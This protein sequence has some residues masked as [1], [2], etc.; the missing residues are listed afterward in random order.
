MS[1]QEIP[2]DVQ[3]K[4][5]DLETRA[6]WLDSASETMDEPKYYQNQAAA[7]WEEARVLAAQYGLT[8]E[9]ED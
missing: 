9:L 1:I 7:L 2:A 4:I 3:E 6:S 8:S 5:I